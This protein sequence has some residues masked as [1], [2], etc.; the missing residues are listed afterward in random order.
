MVRG[1]VPI[2]RT[3]QSRREENIVTM[4]IAMRG[5]GSPCRQRDRPIASMIA[6]TPRAQETALQLIAD[7]GSV[8]YAIARRAAFSSEPDVPPKA[9]SICPIRITAAI[10]LV[11]PVITGARTRL[12]KRPSRNSPRSRI[13]SPK[14]VCFNRTGTSSRCQESLASVTAKRSRC[15]TGRRRRSTPQYRHLSLEKALR[16]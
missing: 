6:A 9:L 7:G 15:M 1:I 8:T 10:P 14:R 2:V 4:A 12:T 3:C 11:K 13:D 16:G 5:A